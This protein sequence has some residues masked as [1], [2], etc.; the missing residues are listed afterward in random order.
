MEVSPASD[1]ASL[2]EALKPIA[3]LSGIRINPA[4]ISAKDLRIKI[5]SSNE[6]KAEIRISYGRGRFLSLIRLNSSR[7]EQWLYR[8][9]QGTE[10]QWSRIEPECQAEAGKIFYQ[11]LEK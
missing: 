3:A 1:T 9:R 5:A 11:M 7:Q 8:Y 10:S 2:Q 4:A 6:E